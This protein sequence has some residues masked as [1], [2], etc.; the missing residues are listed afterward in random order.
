MTLGEL[1]ALARSRLDDLEPEYRWS[2]DLLILWFNEAQIEACRRARLLKDSTTAAV[3]QI[4]FANDA[5]QG[6]LDSRVIRVERAKFGNA[7]FQLRKRSYRDIEECDMNWQDRASATP[8]YFFTDFDAGH[9]NVYPALATA[10]TLNLTV[11]RE[12]LAAMADMDDSP[13]IATRYQFSMVDFVVYRALQSG[14]PDSGDEQ[15]SQ[16]ALAMFEQEFGL[17]SNARSE[18]FEEDNY[19]MSG[20]DGSV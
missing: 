3:C 15:R 6:A 10:D 11:I 1:I 9:V 8:R 4:A 2:D 20:Y 5:S 19:P 17:R 14:D 12:P 7:S 18:R 16:T 13:E